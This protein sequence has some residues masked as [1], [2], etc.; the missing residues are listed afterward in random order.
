MM[1]TMTTMTRLPLGACRSR[2]RWKRRTT[3]IVR[4]GERAGT[5]ATER[6]ATGTDTAVEVAAGTAAENGEGRTKRMELN[7]GRRESTEG[8][9]AEAEAE[10]EA[11]M[12]TA[13]DDRDVAKF[14][15]VEAAVGTIDAGTAAGRGRGPRT[16]TVAG[17]LKGG[18]A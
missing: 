14:L 10:A 7:H 1:I 12:E 15:A 13:N 17:L 9:G 6:I 16:N 2:R 11:E 18:E 3:R 8:I 5:V 4:D